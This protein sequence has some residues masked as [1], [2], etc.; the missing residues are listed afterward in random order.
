VPNFC[1]GASL[2]ALVFLAHGV[3]AAAKSGLLSIEDELR[4]RWRS[5]RH[6]AARIHV[7]CTE[8]EMNRY[9]T[10]QWPSMNGLTVSVSVSVIRR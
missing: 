9:R 10:L 6:F 1:L 4:Q 7:G 2:L 5:A 3:A 8:K